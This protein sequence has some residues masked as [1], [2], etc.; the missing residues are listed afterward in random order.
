MDRIIF[1]SPARE[2]TLTVEAPQVPLS[3]VLKEATL[4]DLQ[5]N[6]LH[7]TDKGQEALGIAQEMKPD[8]WKKREAKQPWEVIQELYLYVDDRRKRRER[9][10]M[11]EM[12]PV[13]Q[14]P[15]PPAGSLPSAG[16][17]PSNR[18]TP[19][20]RRRSAFAGG[21]D[22]RRPSRETPAPARVET[23]PAPKIT[24]STPVDDEVMA[25]LKRTQEYISNPSLRPKSPFKVTPTKSSNKLSERSR[26]DYER[27]RAQFIKSLGEGCTEWDIVARLV[28]TARSKSVS[29]Y[30]KQR[31]V[32]LR[33]FER[34]P[35]MLEAVKLLPPYTELCQLAGREPSR[36]STDVTTARRAKQNPEVFKRLLKELGPGHQ[37]M[38]LLLRYTGARSIELPTVKLT[39]VDEGLQIT[40]T[41]AKTGSRKNP[42]E[43]TRSWV[44][45]PSDGEYKTLMG[46]Y[47]RRGETP[48]KNY[49]PSSLRGAWYRARIRLRLDK[50]GCYDLHS[51]RHQYAS[52]YK[53]R[54]AEEMKL[55]HKRDWRRK[56]YGENWQNNPEYIADFYGP[57][58]QRLGH[59]NAAM[60]RIYG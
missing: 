39:P 38:I 15:A 29:T 6:F 23:R 54:F 40:I 9:A 35:S 24:L 57:I 58:A 31:A 50:A 42:G 11:Q 48:A 44:V 36:R 46:I 53:N 21:G 34:R 52:D 59:T 17:N 49:S 27:T 55:L 5:E 33:L 45:A 16:V 7:K 51:L 4:K 19:P 14:P 8:W 56:L 3:E 10:E 47:T 43:A 60:A 20:P 12:Q 37:D 18:V 2:E 22:T 25:V 26:A 13:V 28:E 1:D 30:K 41:S 32:V